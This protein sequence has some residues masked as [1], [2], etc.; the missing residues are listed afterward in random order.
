MN[1]V[2][3]LQDANAA[4]ASAGAQWHVPVLA[5][6]LLVWLFPFSAI[7]KMLHWDDAMEQARSSI[8]PAS[9]APFLLV[10]A[11]A[12]ELVLPVCIVAGWL[13]PESALVLAA[14]CAVTALLYHRFWACGDF[15]KKRGPSKGR[16]HFW[17]F[18]KN[19]GLAG[20]LL[21]IVIGRGF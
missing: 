6:V 8:V 5:R 12:A 3:H 4:L 21:Y 20:G 9:W 19:F 17:D 14:Y 13:A 11:M 7:D 1:L 10:C 16:T 2:Q 18:L 15:W